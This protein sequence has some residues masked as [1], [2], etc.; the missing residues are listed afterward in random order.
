MVCPELLVGDGQRNGRAAG[1]SAENRGQEAVK[2]LT[3]SASERVDC[4]CE[5]RLS[6]SSSVI[7]QP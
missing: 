6:C 7:H 2:K 4:G 3:R 1:Q 5:G